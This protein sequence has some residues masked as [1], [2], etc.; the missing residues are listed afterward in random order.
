MKAWMLL[1]AVVVSACQSSPS[2]PA[3]EQQPAK[4]PTKKEASNGGARQ[5]ANADAEPINAGEAE[6]EEPQVAAKQ[7]TLS[8]AGPFSVGDGTLEGTWQEDGPKREGCFRG[9]NFPEYQQTDRVVKI[10]LHIEGVVGKAKIRLK[11]CGASA[12]FYAAKA[13][14]YKDGVMVAEMGRISKAQDAGVM[15]GTDLAVNLA[16][17]QRLETGDYMIVI[18][19]EEAN[20]VQQDRT[21]PYEDMAIKDVEFIM[22]SGD[23]ELTKTEIILSSSL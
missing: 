18:S 13:W 11:S 7:A 23:A 3:V 12:D 4:T 17:G 22:V 6:Y 14:L 8:F 19:A 16:D 9:M 10:G 1:I 2:Q 20:G 15:T 21:G 5:E